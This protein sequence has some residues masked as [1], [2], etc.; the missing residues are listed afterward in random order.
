MLTHQ[1]ALLDLSLL[2]VAL[3]SHRIDALTVLLRDHLVILHLLH[4]L[5]HLLIVALFEFHDL[6]GTLTRLLNLLPS[7]DLLLLE[8]GDTVGQQLRIALHTAHM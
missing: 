5:R 7:L 8:K 6:A 1:N 4:L 2:Y 3:L